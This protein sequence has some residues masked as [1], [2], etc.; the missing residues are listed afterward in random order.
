[1]ILWSSKSGKSNPN[2]KHL[3]I[4]SVKNLY[5]LMKIQIFFQSKYI[6]VEN[7]NFDPLYTSGGIKINS[8]GVNDESSF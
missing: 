3:M 8:F 1:M 7:T 5:L 4:C 6:E 2:Y